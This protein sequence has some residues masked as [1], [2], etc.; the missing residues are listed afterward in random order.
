Y[1]IPTRA[2]TVGVRG[3]T[4]ELIVTP[5]GISTV[6]LSRGSVIVAN[7]K[8]DNVVLKPGEATTILPP[9][10]DGSQ[11]PPSPPGPLAAD[12]QQLL[13]NMTGAILAAD[14]PSDVNPSAGGSGATTPA[15][16]KNNG[17]SNG[18]PTGDPGSGF[19]PV[20]FPQFNP[21]LTSAGV[22]IVVPHQN[23]PTSPTSNSSGGGG[24]GGGGNNGG[25]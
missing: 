12:L 14:P 16:F 19:G 13:W 11:Q 21:N 25:G 4:M 6:A 15:S 7:T 17:P 3:T 8:G 20:T 9:D 1:G 24:N 5:G 18:G 2:A 10:D 22:P 23:G